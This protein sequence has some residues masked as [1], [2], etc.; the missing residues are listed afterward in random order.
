MPLLSDKWIKK[1][2]NHFTNDGNGSL[3]INC[4][5]STTAVGA[6]GLYVVTDTDGT[7]A[8]NSDVKV[9]SQKAIKTYADT[10]MPASYL[11]TT[12]ILGT[13]DAKVPSQ[14]A[15]KTYV[16]NAF[17]A[18][19]AMVF[20]GTIGTGGTYTD[21]TAFNAVTTYNEG[22]TYKVI[23]ALTIKG[24]VCHIGDLL[25]CLQARAGSSNSDDDWTVVPADLDG[26]VIGPAS[27]TNGSLVVFNGTTGKAVTGVG[28]GHTV[29]AI[30]QKTYYHKIIA[31]E[32]SAGKFALP[33]TFVSASYLTASVVGGIALTNYA[34]VGATGAVP[35]FKISSSD[36]CFTTAVAGVTVSEIL[37][38][39]DIVII[40]G[41]NS[42]AV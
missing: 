9:A 4:N 22:W 41:N 29:E 5:P 38:T 7:L 32:L 40:T 28:G 34:H 31:A 14:N 2:A 12:A 25:I 20:K 33:G 16:D 1:I 24:N 10:K 36:F 23:T 18:N 17:A 15:V 37:T 21:G 30:W 35:D 27:A 19:D 26:A 39:N 6:S 11:D 42:V 3:G 8:S 13:N